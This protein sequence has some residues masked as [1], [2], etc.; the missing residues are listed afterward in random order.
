MMPFQNNRS[1]STGTEYAESGASFGIFSPGMM[2]DEAG[3]MTEDSV[4]LRTWLGWMIEVSL[5]DRV[6]ATRRRIGTYRDY[7]RTALE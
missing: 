5:G 4:C 3:E 6:I 7:A 2:L 1:A